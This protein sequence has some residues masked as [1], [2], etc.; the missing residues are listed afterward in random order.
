MSSLLLIFLAVLVRLFFALGRKSQEVKSEFDII[1]YF[2]IRHVIRWSG[3]LLT[4]FTM[5]FFVPDFV[6]DYLAPKYF[7]TFKEWSAIGDFVIGFAGYDLI[8]LAE[9]LTKSKVDKLTGGK[10]K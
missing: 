7:P 5:S 2:D 8:K 1:K 3:H 10:I 6:V 9:K 4:A